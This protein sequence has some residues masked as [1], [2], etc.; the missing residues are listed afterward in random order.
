M[1]INIVPNRGSSPTVLLRESYREGAK[2]CKRTLANLSALSAAQVQ[3]IRASLRGDVLQPIDQTFEITASAAHGHVQAVSMA[4]QRLGFASL[5]ASKVCPERD[6]VAAMVASRII[7]PT[8]KLATT[9]LWHTSTL[10]TE[11]G[12][13]DATEDD[14]YAAMDWLLAG[15]DRIQK[16]LAGRHLQEDA[17]VLYDLSSSYFEGSHCP[18]AKLGYS[19]DGKRGT[20]QVNYGLLTD[21]RGCPVAISVHEGNTSDSTTFMPEVTRL[22]E[23]FGI[24]RMVMVGDRG[25]ISQKAI[26]EMS[27]DADLAWITALRSSSIR[28]LVAQGAVQ[29]G[30]FDERNLLEISS[31]DFPGERLVAC[32]NPEL[33]KLRM[34]TRNDLLAATERNLEKIKVRVEAGKLVG[35]DKIGVAVGKVVNQYKVAKHFELTIADDSFTFARLADNIVAE[36]ALD[37][38]YI[39]RTSVTAQR[40]DAPTCVRTY[41]SLSQVERAFRSIKTMDL[42]VRPIHHRLEGRVRAHIFLCMLAYYVEWHMRQAWAPLLFAD[43]D[44]AAKLVRDPVAPAK[45]SDT[46]MKKVL[47]RTQD[48]GSPVHSFQTLMAQLQAIVRNTCRTPGGASDAPT[49]EIITTPNHTQRHALDL[50][51]QIKQ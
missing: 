25:M 24:K 23:A 36:A 33:A 31:P 42:K 26:N 32:R 28:T 1:H 27:K 29:M 34:H 7:C 10:A 6:L 3:M 20:L 18:L 22:R 39:I 11:F 35:Q 46:A 37:G 47:S 44:Q 40:M 43:E 2:V 30:L 15:Q 9:R 21:D 51:D 48:D 41:K 5:L 38:L 4:M 13:A 12:V 8:T 17:L 16:K 49:F 50:I 14:L 45:R 19:R